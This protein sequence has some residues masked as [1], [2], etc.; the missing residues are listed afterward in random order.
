MPEDAEKGR[1]RAILERLHTWLIDALEA[2]NYEGYFVTMNKNFPITRASSMPLITVSL[3]PHRLFTEVYGRRYPNKGQTAL[4]PFT[5]FIYHWKTDMGEYS[6][7]YDVHILSDLIVKYLRTKSSDS[8]ERNTHGIY[9]IEDVLLRESDPV[10][11]R[12]LTRIILSGDI[13][14]TR[15]DET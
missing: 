3:G 15:E 11:A 13:L 1:R 7:N 10:G 14:A 2:N 4:F 9:R 5:C 8:T 6:H 12:K